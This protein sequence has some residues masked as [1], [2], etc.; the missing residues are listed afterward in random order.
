MFDEASAKG[1]LLNNL[2]IKDNHMI[3]LDSGQQDK[4]ALKK[5]V[6]ELQ[7]LPPRW[8][9][10]VGSESS[11]M[12]RGLRRKEI[13]DHLTAFLAEVR[14]EKVDLGSNNAFLRPSTSA[15]SVA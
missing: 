1:M 4:Q 10:L 13:S 6:K 12:Q 14:G 2:V 9:Q 8:K 3:T 7:A 5:E 11:E 15:S